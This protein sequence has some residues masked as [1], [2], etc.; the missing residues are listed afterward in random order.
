MNRSMNIKGFL[1]L[2]GVI[3]V[4]FLPLHILMKSDLHR[5]HDMEEELNAK[6]ARL[7]EENQYL[8]TQLSIIGTDEYIAQSAIQNYSYVSRD[9]IRFVFTNPEALEAYT[10]AEIQIMA[11]EMAD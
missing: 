5:K 8:T 10:E 9:D 11:E 1:L 4:I 6:R 3:L 7:E 2:L